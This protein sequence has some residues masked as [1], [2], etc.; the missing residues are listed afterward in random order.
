MSILALSFV[1]ASNSIQP[2]KRH[3]P[4]SV[5]F[6]I[7][8]FLGNDDDYYNFNDSHE[9]S[10]LFFSV[11]YSTSFAGFTENCFLICAISY[12]YLFLFFKLW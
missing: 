6:F 10:T 8:Q 7:S 1:E 2:P 4:H 5:F 12:F 11:F 9:K 3:S